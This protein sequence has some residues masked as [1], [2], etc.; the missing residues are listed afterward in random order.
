VIKEEKPMG[1]VVLIVEDEHKN[2]KLVRDILNLSGYATLEA[3]DGPQGISAAKKSSPDLI[4]MDIQLPMMDGVESTRILK[5]DPNT[6]N[7]PVMALTSYAM[8]GD[9]RKILEA[10]FD[11]YMTKPLDVDKFLEMVSNFLSS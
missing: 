8:K 11:A 10:G 5:G 4:L 6:K 7:I 1:K 9:K 2:L 3:T